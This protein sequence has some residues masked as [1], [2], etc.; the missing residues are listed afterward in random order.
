MVF[1]GFFSQNIPSPAPTATTAQYN[2]NSLNIAN[3]TAANDTIQPFAGDIHF[4]SDGTKAILTNLSQ[5]A[6]GGKIYTLP[7]STA[8]DITTIGTQSSTSY[9]SNH[10]GNG[11]MYGIS[12]NS[13]G[14]IMITVR[15][16]DAN[17]TT[18]YVYS[19]S[20]PYN[21]SNYTVLNSNW[22]I[23]HS[24]TLDIDNAQGLHYYE[25]GGSPYVLVSSLDTD[26]GLASFR[27]QDPTNNSWGSNSDKI[28][29]LQHNTTYK[30]TC[31]W[32][33]DDGTNVYG[34]MNN[35]LYQLTLSTAYDI[36]TATT[37][38]TVVVGQNFNGLFFITESS[39]TKY[40]VY[41]TTTNTASTGD[42]IFKVQL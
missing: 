6:D 26:R 41:T 12:F 18:Y 14:T 32:M 10:A 29:T 4:S 23:G 35:T 8:Y 33:N 24:G 13:D 5:G 27:L 31:V 1:A 16:K 2:I 17:N 11:E 28:S 38:N 22:E 19:L 30:F 39:G 34:T 25:S 7:L 20:T 40:M 9:P 3:A 15:N 37:D 21:A 42:N 36:T